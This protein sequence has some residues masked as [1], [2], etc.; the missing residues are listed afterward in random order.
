MDDFGLWAIGIMFAFF[1]IVFLMSE[2][3]HIRDGELE[4]TEEKLRIKRQEL[5]RIQSMIDNSSLDRGTGLTQTQVKVLDKYERSNIRIP[6]DILEELPHIVH[7]SES[8]TLEYIEHQRNHWKLENSKK[9]YK[10]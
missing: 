1:I 10:K 9:V 2:W 3:K 8:D 4:E 7:L 6:A 5:D